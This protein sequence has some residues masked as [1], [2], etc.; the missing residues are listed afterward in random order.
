MFFENTQG[1]AGELTEKWPVRFKPRGAYERLCETTSTKVNIL[2][3][4]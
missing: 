1:K 4:P 3:V 2:P